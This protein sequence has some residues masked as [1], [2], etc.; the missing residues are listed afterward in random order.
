MSNVTIHSAP[1]GGVRVF[2]TFLG[3]SGG[4]SGPTGPTG[5]TG[6]SGGT[7]G[8]GATGATGPTGYPYPTDGISG[9]A[10]GYVNSDVSWRNLNTQVLNALRLATDENLILVETD[11]AEAA[12][13]DSENG[14]KYFYF[15]LKLSEGEMLSVSLSDIVYATGSTLTLAAAVAGYRYSGYSLKIE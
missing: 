10:L 15:L 3:Y 9:Q 8:T 14:E 12:V 1:A 2:E 6:S 13:I 5:P 4:V 7:G 11:F